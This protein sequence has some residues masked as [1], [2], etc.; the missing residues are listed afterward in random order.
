[1][2]LVFTPM[3]FFQVVGWV[4]TTVGILSHVHT[5]LSVQEAKQKWMEAAQR[6]MTSDLHEIRK[7]VKLLLTH[8]HSEDL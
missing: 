6:D 2:E 7:D 8:M 4:V 3:D 1:M 5:R